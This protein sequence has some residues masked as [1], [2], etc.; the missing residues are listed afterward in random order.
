[1]K[2]V[3]K[4]IAVG[5][6]IGLLLLLIRGLFQIE[7]GI[8]LRGY[9][10]LAAVVLVGTVLFN[11]LYQISYQRRLQKLVPLLDQGDTEGYLTGVRALLETARG[12]ALRSVLQLDLAAGY[13][14]AKELGRAIQLLEGL[15]VSRSRTVELCRR[16]DLCLAYFE[17]ERPE[18]AM[19]VYRDSGALLAEGR[20]RAPYGG[21]IAVA[22]ILAAL[23]EGDRPRAEEQIRA[24]QAA[25]PEPRVQRALT[26]IGERLDKK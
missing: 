1:M 12:R 3:A 23:Q 25:W 22:D 11:V 16:L 7:E 24:A 10:V 4:I 17:A 19:V 20:G 2:R 13:L 8:F 14:E 6:A 5:I 21:T 9:L 18:D 26:E 15:P